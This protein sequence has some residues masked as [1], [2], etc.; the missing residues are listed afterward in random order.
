MDEP[1]EFL[2]GRISSEW[3]ENV[4]NNPVKVWQFNHYNAEEILRDVP[5]NR[6]GGLA[7]RFGQELLL[8]K[9]MGRLHKSHS[10]VD[11]VLGSEVGLMTDTKQLLNAAQ[12]QRE[13]DH[14]LIE[15][16]TQR[17]RP[18]SNLGHD[19]NENWLF[20]ITALTLGITNTN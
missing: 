6:L 9:D 7:V 14:L 3:A 16:L 15:A 18:N 19:G 11:L 10:C 20:P 2:T 13:D 8:P 12:Q 4:Y 17:S 5:V 1:V